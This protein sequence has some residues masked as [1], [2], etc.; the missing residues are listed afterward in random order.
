[1]PVD[2]SQTEPSKKRSSKKRR[3]KQKL[4]SKQPIRETNQTAHSVRTLRNGLYFRF[5]DEILY[6]SV[7]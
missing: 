2:G 7:I 4:K 3:S 1:M 5:L 6:L